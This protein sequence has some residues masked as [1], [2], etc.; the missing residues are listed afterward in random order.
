MT[1]KYYNSIITSIFFIFCGIGG[2]LALFYMI[3]SKI[4]KFDKIMD[5]IAFF[6]FLITGILALMSWGY[7]VTITSDTFNWGFFCINAISLP[8]E[9]LVGTSVTFPY[10]F[11]MFYT[12]DGKLT[13]FWCSISY[14][15]Y[16]E[17]C[18][19]IIGNNPN[20][21]VEKRIKKKLVKR[22]GL[23]ADDIKEMKS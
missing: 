11:M 23:N 19:T 14:K 4:M 5:F 20:F 21:A 1:K 8:Y 16:Y 13:W 3:N 2:L 6:I 15:N 22:Y 12:K 17:L 10:W 7:N 9:D 18:K